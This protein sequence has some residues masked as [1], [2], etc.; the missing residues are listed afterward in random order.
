[1][2]E[3][4]TVVSGSVEEA[5]VKLSFTQ[6]RAAEDLRLSG[7]QLRRV[8]KGEQ[9][10]YLETLMQA[11]R[12]WPVF[13]RCLFER[14]HKSGHLKIRSPRAHEMTVKRGAKKRKVRTTKR[15]VSK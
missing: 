10:I 2:S 4:R 12:I 7:R 1:M 9:P 14:E 15:K 11:E 3:V 13:F 8:L 5:R 6:E